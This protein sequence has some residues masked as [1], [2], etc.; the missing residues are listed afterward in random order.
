MIKAGVQ[1]TWYVSYRL[2]ERP[3]NKDYSC[4]MS[5]PFPNEAAAKNFARSILAE[6][7]LVTAGTLNPHL[8]KRVIVPARITQWLESEPCS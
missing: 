4:R 7:R 3:P 6:A 1:N 5:E 2:R 8:P